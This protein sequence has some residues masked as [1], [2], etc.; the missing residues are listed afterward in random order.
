MI[1]DFS[2]ETVQARIQW[3]KICKIIKGLKYRTQ[4]KYSSK[5]EVKEKTFQIHER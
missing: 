3:S 5:M 2:L 4:Q 1:I